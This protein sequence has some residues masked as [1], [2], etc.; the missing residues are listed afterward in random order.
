MKS[1]SHRR[2]PSSGRIARRRASLLVPEPLEGRRLFAA[3]AFRSPTPV[4][5]GTYAEST[6]SLDFDSDGM[7]DFA[8]ADFNTSSITVVT[9]HGDGTFAAPLR[10]NIGFPTRRIAA[11]D[12][13]RD[14]K[15]DIAG[16][17][18]DL[19][20][21]SSGLV[22]IRF[23]NGS[24]ASVSTIVEPRSLAVADLNHDSK[25][26]LVVV[27]SLGGTNPVCVSV[28]LGDGAGHFA[29]AKTFAGPG[30]ASQ[31]AVADFNSDSNPDLAIGGVDGIRVLLGAGNG[32][33]SP[34]SAVSAGGVVAGL[35]VADISLDG[36]P[37]LLASHAYNGDNRLSV[38]V[39]TG[40]AV[41]AAP[42]DYAVASNP[43]AIAVGDFSG[44]GVVDVAVVS[45]SNAAVSILR[46]LSSGGLLGNRIDL[47]T[48][49]LCLT[50]VADTFDGDS[51]LDLLV[52]SRE[53]AQLHP[54][55]G[56][57][58]DGTRHFTTP[59]DAQDSL[60]ADFNNDGRPDLATS[61]FSDDIVTIRLGGLGGTLTTRPDLTT[62]YGPWGLASAD[63]NRDGNADLAVS[64]WRSSKV[65]VFLGD[66][67]GTFQPRSDYLVAPGPAG[68]TTADLDNDGFPEIIASG[69]N[70]TYISIL[71]NRKDGTFNPST[72]DLI[73]PE[74]TWDV[75][76]ADFNLDGK[77]DIAAPVRDVFGSAKLWL[78]LANRD[79][80]FT[81]SQIVVGS[82]LHMNGIVAADFNAD[83]KPD[84]AT[85]NYNDKSV[86]VLLGNGSGGFAVSKLANIGLSPYDIAAGDVNRDGK[87]DLL[88]AAY[89]ANSAVVLLSDGSGG[90][91]A[92]V[93]FA[94]AQMPCSVAV[95]DI[96]GDGAPD[97]VLATEGG[98]PGTSVV[99][100][101]RSSSAP[102]ASRLTV[103]GTSG[104]IPLA[105]LL[106]DPESNPASIRV[107]FSRD[108]GATWKSATPIAGSDAT[109]LATSVD[110]TSHTFRWNSQA[111]LV[112]ASGNVRLRVTPSDTVTGYTGYSP[113]FYVTNVAPTPPAKPASLALSTSTLSESSAPGTSLG[114]LT[115]NA[116]AVTYSLAPA[117]KS[118]DNSLVTLVGNELRLAA[119]IDFETHP[120]L[121]I[122]LQATN[123]AGTLA[124]TLSVK[125]TDSPESP[126]DILLSK[127]T[128]AEN[129]K[130]G[131][132]LGSLSA[133]DA[134]KRE[135]FTFALVSG[136]EHN[137]LFTLSGT[138]LR[139]TAPLDFESTPTLHIRLAV[140][141]S[142]GQR[143]EK[144]LNITVTN[145]NE[146][147][148]GLT[149]SSTSLPALASP[150]TL[151]ATLT[152]LDPD[153]NDRF[154]Y[155][156]VAGQGSSHNKL[157]RISGNQLTFAGPLP[158]SAP[159]SLTIRLQVKDKLGKTFQL[160][161]PITLN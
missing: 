122:A 92:P 153:A 141:D 88:V 107:E 117:A 66:G 75:A 130:A 109:A 81:S 132:T 85:A 99:P 40:N 78:F 25:L 116:G 139:T 4:V 46:N 149:L 44:N 72:G 76:V 86:S 20:G 135:K 34:G 100:A 12:F 26:D 2:T 147:P 49:P 142:R 104:V 114:T 124:R 15:P 74:H 97:L 9:G 32:N 148:T 125:I 50:I 60:L 13:D 29:A 47:I 62:H 53:S 151:L 136:G 106:R 157:F 56:A 30:G 70:A 87:P 156:L 77:L 119:P 140:T 133:R 59:H 10:L 84:L 16:S 105:F 103:S 36:K 48:Q 17:V 6:I 126:T 102:D 93:A 155:S 42:V 65:S 96:T 152:P 115:C 18:F 158:Q 79:V 23:G 150:G 43:G 94:T 71:R 82:Q 33:F 41:F 137:S 67:D 159:A 69:S 55:V 19:S 52:A 108:A 161:V 90:F 54:A 37:D 120:S 128:I 14:S 112:G 98:F 38:I 118:N 57:V 83:G 127:L 131:T 145:A 7:R 8:Q 58:P 111:D 27:S 89:A 146:A 51:A 22:A 144:L 101:E 28:L 134:D 24:L 113:V 45:E 95:G 123:S 80:G 11:G 121:R 35:A 31:I 3:L 63:F 1:R 154:T 21:S 143:F 64:D 61:V 138:S 110:G 73:V 39:N 5:S 129:L 68:I 91:S 160:A